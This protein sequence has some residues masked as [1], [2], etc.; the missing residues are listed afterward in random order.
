MTGANIPNN[1]PST[2]PPEPVVTIQTVVSNASTEA[3][4]TGALHGDVLTANSSIILPTANNASTTPNTS[5]SHHIPP[6]LKTPPSAPFSPWI[7]HTTVQKQETTDANSTQEETSS[8]A[9]VRTSSLLPATTSTDFSKTSSPPKPPLPTS[10]DSAINKQTSTASTTT[11]TTT[12]ANATNKQTSTV[13]ATTLTTTIDRTLLANDK[14]TIVS[15]KNS[16]KLPNTNIPPLSEFTVC[17]DLCPDGSASAW[18]AFSYCAEN[19]NKPLELGLGLLA[20]KLHISHLGEVHEFDKALKE[21]EWHS[22]CL[23]WQ[24]STRQLV[25]YLNG[26]HVYNTTTKDAS[27]KGYGSLVLGATHTRNDGKIAIT[28]GLNFVGDLYYFQLWSYARS[29]DELGDCSEGN[30]LSW[31]TQPWNFQR[32]SKDERLHCANATNEQTSTA[33]TTTLTT[34][35]ANATNEQTSTASTTTLTTPIANA[36]NEQTSTASTTTLTTPIA[37]A[38]NEQTS[39][40]ST[41]TLTTPIVMFYVVTMRITIQPNGNIDAEQVLTLMEN[42]MVYLLKDP[43]FALMQ[44]IVTDSLSNELGNVPTHKSN[45]KRRGTNVD[46][47]ASNYNS[48]SIVQANSSGSPELL[49]AK[50]KNLLENQDYTDPQLNNI[51]ASVQSVSIDLL[52]PGSCPSNSTIYNGEGTYNWTETKPTE[53]G[54]APCHRNPDEFATR[55]CYINVNTECAEWQTPNYTRCLPGS[56]ETIENII[57]TPENANYLAEQILNMTKIASSLPENTIRI[58]LGKLSEIVTLGK[59]DVENGKINLDL[60][61]SILTKAD[62]SLHIFTNKILNITEEIGFKM[63]FPGDTEYVTV[64]SLAFLVTN[65]NFKD[66]KEVYFNV[67]SYLEGKNIEI[68]LENVPAVKAVGY[69]H[70]PEAIKDQAIAAASKVQFNFFGTPSLFKGNESSDLILNSYIVS[71]SVEGTNIEELNEPVTITLRHINENVDELPVK[72]VFWDFT[73][74]NN[75]GGW[76]TSGCLQTSTNL[77]YT[78]CNCTHL[79]HFGVLLDISK[80]PINPYDDHILSLLTYVGCGIAALCLGISLVTYGM[81]KQLR[82]D[83]P[84]KI[85]MNLSFSLLMLNMIF[86]LNNWLSSFRIQGLCIST[87]AL[88][89]YFLLTSFT[90]MGLEAIHMYFAFVKVFHSYINKYILKLCIAGWGIPIIVV[91]IVL[92]IDT[93][94]YGY[95]S[96]HK[97]NADTDD[98]SSLFCWIQ[99]DVVFYVAVVAYFVI[100]FLTN[101]SMF[102]VVLLQIKLLKATKTQDWKTLFLHDIKNTLSLAFLLGLTWGFVFFAWGPVRTAFLYLFAIFNTLQGFFIFVFHCVMKENVRKHWRM[103]LCCGKCRLDIYS[104]WSRLSNVDTKHGRIRMSPSDSIQ[105]NNT[106]STSNASSLSGYYRDGYYERSFPNGGG[107]YINYAATAPSIHATVFPQARR[108]NADSRKILSLMELDAQLN[109]L[110]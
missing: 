2:Q 61:N 40:A 33:S 34:P 37:N 67:K 53:T 44:I 90:W 19:G 79:T 108:A 99:N 97:Q 41:T 27:L 30:L 4:S 87:A 85:L 52:D 95:G 16:G 83:Y 66:F 72:C 28:D 54:R 94:F 89:H 107:I 81:F 78:S 22:V 80:T 36:T 6:T 104:D 46:S 23:M 77:E 59:L 25:V 73:L 56:F 8:L 20:N 62:D 96:E 68:S 5:L 48:K 45:K 10:T 75:L 26:T 13:G 106:A 69:I 102:I 50:L 88:L 18:T 47:G 3:S 35:I 76:N 24:R 11:P 31:T 105:S 43:E 101:I 1:T 91:V 64:D 14:A 21:H 100:I 38:T 12:I 98:S 32:V 51:I 49:A 57:V 110:R 103:Y 17:L 70:L 86:L 7:N 82:R 92:G 60:I 71:A 29:Q 42:M 9:I 63:N 55:Y 74:N 65:V 93:N 39:T 15:E 109:R 58:I 84:S